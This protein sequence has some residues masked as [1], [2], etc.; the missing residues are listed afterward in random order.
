MSDAD[1]FELSLLSASQASTMLNVYLSL[2]F[3]YLI[4][5][6]IIGASLSTFQAV[7]LSSLYTVGVIPALVANYYYS[8]RA[9]EFELL[10]GATYDITSNDSLGN[11]V[12]WASYMAVVLTAG[13]LVSYYFMWN[14]RHSKSA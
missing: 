6:Y 5:S 9:A 12:T 8:I 13:V 3:G 14:V 7:V 4:T 1:L 11:A 2:T 10:I